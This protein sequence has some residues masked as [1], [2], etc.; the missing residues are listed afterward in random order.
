MLVAV[1]LSSGCARKAP[2]PPP[3]PWSGPAAAPTGVNPAEPPRV[4]FFRGPV[5]KWVIPWTE[6]LTLSKAILEAEYTGLWDPYRITVTRKGQVFEI[7]P[8]RLL[9]GLDDL[10]LEPGDIVE[11]Q[12]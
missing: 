4:V 12:R 3:P 5:R 6:E 10:P 2:P 8:K 11:L 1:L 9:Q 7:K